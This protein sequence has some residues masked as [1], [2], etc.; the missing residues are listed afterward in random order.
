MVLFLRIMRAIEIKSLFE[1]T[2][3]KKSHGGKSGHWV[4]YII[5]PVVIITGSLKKCFHRIF[6]PI[7]SLHYMFP[8]WEWKNT[9]VLDLAKK[10]NYQGWWLNFS[11]ETAEWSKP[12]VHNWAHTTQ[13]I[14][15]TLENCMV[16]LIIYCLS[17]GK[18]LMISNSSTIKEIAEHDFDCRSASAFKF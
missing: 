10:E 18:K 6:F 12:N 4:V 14:S 7:L 13:A 8:F 17:F 2:P 1:V 11:P 9:K 16:E 3:P 15:Q 5:L